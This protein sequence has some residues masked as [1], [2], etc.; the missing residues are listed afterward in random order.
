[1]AVGSKKKFHNHDFLTNGGIL[2]PARIAAP[3]AGDST[4]LANAGDV[5]YASTSGVLRYRN[6]SNNVLVGS[7][8]VHLTG[9]TSAISTGTNTS[10][11]LTIPFPGL[12][13]F[14]ATVFVQGNGTAS[15]PAFRLAGTA[16]TSAWRVSAVAN[17]AAATD[18]DLILAGTTLPGTATSISTSL[19]TSTSSRAILIDGSFTA[20]AVGSVQLEF[21]RITGSGTYVLKNNSIYSMQQVS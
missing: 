7:L 10:L 6:G 15:T 17:F 21:S 14:R 4:L 9:D 19:S 5:G 13:V 2:Q 16:T 18:A 8:L 3:S 1:M 12:Y 20:S 11:T